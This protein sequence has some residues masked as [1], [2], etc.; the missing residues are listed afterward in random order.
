MHNGFKASLGHR[1]NWSPPLLHIKPCPKITKTNKINKEDVEAPAFYFQLLWGE[2][3]S[4]PLSPSVLTL[5]QDQSTGPI[6]HGLKASGLRAL[7]NLSSLWLAIF[8]HHSDKSFPTSSLQ[9]SSLT[10][11]RKCF[12]L[13]WNILEMTL[14]GNKVIIKVPY[15]FLSLGIWDYL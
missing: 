13:F 3:L 1:V 12:Y 7:I 15:I 8:Y 5:P 14:F 11:I 6:D 2:Q 9:Q 10:V 4:P